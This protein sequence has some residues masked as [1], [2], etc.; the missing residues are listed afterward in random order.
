M[1]ID[2]M[3]PEAEA[4]LADPARTCSLSIGVH[5]HPRTDSV[6]PHAP[7]SQCAS[8]SEPSG[9][10]LTRPASRTWT[11]YA[12]ACRSRRHAMRPCLTLRR[13]QLG[14]FRARAQMAPAVGILA[15]L[16]DQAYAHYYT[17][18]MRNWGV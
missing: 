3:T 9:K 4:S 6:P 1:P 5:V 8:A 14:G 13:R 12:W 17:L 2:V 10:R 7:P 15:A 11:R 18:K 16:E